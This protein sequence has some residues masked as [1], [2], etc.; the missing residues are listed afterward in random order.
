M[1]WRRTRPAT[2][3]KM[4]STE[5][6]L[7]EFIGQFTHD[8]LGFTECVYPWG[9]GDL[10]ESQG[11]R[12][13]QRKEL[14]TIGKHLRNPETR[15]TPLLISVASGHGIG[16]SSLIAQ[17]VNWGMSTC[18][19]CKIIITA[20]TDTQ[21]R[22]KT[23]PEVTKWMNLSLTGHWFEVTATS[24]FAKEPKHQRTWRCDAIPWSEHN[25]EAFAGMHNKGKRIIILFDESSAISAK[26][27]EVIEGALTDENTE[28]IWVAFGNPT[29][30]TGRFR[31]C[32]GK[33]KH[34]WIGS[35]IDSRT[36]EGTNKKQID[37]WIQ[38]Y[39]E[40]SDFVRIRVKGEFPRAGSMQFISSDI[41]E[42]ARKRDPVA[43]LH[44]PVVMGVDC[45]R[46]GDDESVIVIRRGRDACS[47]PWVKL[48][49]QDT[50]TVAA[51]VME[52][53]MIHKPD[54]IFIDGGGVGG[55]V[56]DRLRQLKLHIIEIQFG[57]KA[58]RAVDTNDGPVIYANKR[59]EMW[60]AMRSAMPG[61]SIPDDPDLADQLV[62]VQYGYTL[63]EG[64]DAI[65][66]EKKK[67]M[68]KRGLA[69]PDRAD[70]LA[71]TYAYPVVPTDHT[72]Q[73]TTRGHT[74]VQFSYDPLD[75]K[76]IKKDYQT[77]NQSS[78]DPLSIENIRS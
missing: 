36:V 58:D 74:G 40:D 76:H 22:T 48:R 24:V 32:F 10:A 31:E 17:I 50:M 73:L 60:G 70:A 11:P 21:L 18:V 65:I 52:L 27:W 66:L 28:I 9:K 26:I 19:D 42:D 43:Y 45:A 1:L 37:K 59:A 15:Y 49:G 56:V 34:R 25:T 23:C 16:K 13:W 71:L 61:L 38:D 14:D 44:D 67:D 77:R 54:A 63:K 62:G 46:F 7:V 3:G 41:V 33:F 5:E 64:K 8:P 75:A 57:A 68:K 51:K 39:G 12:K 78:Y 35:Q 4:L 72:Q 6:K 53:A 55:G 29:Q 2:K 69:S 30:N 20:N 47:I